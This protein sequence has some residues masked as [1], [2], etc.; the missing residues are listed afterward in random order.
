[1]CLC[2]LVLVPVLLCE[3]GC[4]GACLCHSRLWI[5][6][7]ISSPQKQN[8][9]F[10]RQVPALS[11]PPRSSLA[12]QSSSLLGLL[13]KVFFLHCSFFSSEIVLSLSLQIIFLALFFF[14]FPIHISG[15]PYPAPRPSVAPPFCS[16]L[17]PPPT[18][19]HAGLE[20]L[21]LPHY[22]FPRFPHEQKETQ[23][24]FLRPSLDSGSSRQAG[25]SRLWTLSLH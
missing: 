3:P 4:W 22:R 18:T 10:Q 1:M 15:S 2:L 6:K 13:Q 12:P 24:S 19:K 20:S 7:T 17:T 25:D 21:E 14:L 16:S 11:I 8:P 9:A 5:T 23:A